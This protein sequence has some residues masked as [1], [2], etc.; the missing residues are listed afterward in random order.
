MESKKI[1]GLVLSGGKSTRMGTDKS[2][3]TYHGIPQREY[4]YQLLEKVCEKVFLS[5]REDQLEAVPDYMSTITDMDE[6][7]G[8]YNGILSAHK[9]YPEASWL[10]FACDMPL[11]DLKSLEQL[12]TSRNI[13]KIASAFATRESGL[14]EPLAA[15]W[16]PQ[17][18]KKS[19]QYLDNGTTTCPRKFLINADTAL[20]Y[21]DREEVLMN[22]N[23]KVEYAEAL[24]KLTI[25]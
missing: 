14:P 4:M 16:E 2:L 6:Y 21:P 7:R 24:T 20:V 3:I 23:S 10:V 8:P 1:Y 13:E 17:A 12:V 19:I 11:I 22:A 5:V 25:T 18:L 9:K 15:I